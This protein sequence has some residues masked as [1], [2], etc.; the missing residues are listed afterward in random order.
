MR[1]MT[2]NVKCPECGKPEA[3]CHWVDV[4]GVSYVDSYTIKC[5]GCGYTN[6]TEKTGGDSVMGGSSTTCP[7]CDQ[8][9]GTTHNK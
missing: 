9:Q 4:G 3:D 6:T 1:V 8:E 2:K 5:R 7:Y